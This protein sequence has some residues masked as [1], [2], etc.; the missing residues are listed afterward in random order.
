MLGLSMAL[1]A[2]NGESYLDLEKRKADALTQRNGSER[3][4]GWTSSRT[5]PR[6]L[7]AWHHRQI[8]SGNFRSSLLASAAQ[9]RTRLSTLYAPLSG[10][11]SRPFL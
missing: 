9:F 1:D 6:S 10:L 11:F 3:T 8:S 2:F 7:A 4:Q 5:H